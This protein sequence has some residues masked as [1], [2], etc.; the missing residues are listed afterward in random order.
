MAGALE[1]WVR[2]ASRAETMVGVGGGSA[3]GLEAGPA[4]V[5]VAAWAAGV[6]WVVSSAAV[7]D[8]SCPDAVVASGLGVGNTQPAKA[9]RAM[10]R[11]I[12]IESFIYLRYQ[13]SSVDLERFGVEPEETP[14]A[15]AGMAVLLQ[16]NPSLR[17]LPAEG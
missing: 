2:D 9:R 1:Y 13:V 16:F 6:A 10:R 4:G 5:A 12:I 15:L 8:E 14:V 17:L 7:V 3:V 11:A